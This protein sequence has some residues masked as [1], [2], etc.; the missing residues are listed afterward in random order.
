MVGGPLPSQQNYQQG[1]VRDDLRPTRSGQLLTF[2]GLVQ[3]Y[4]NYIFYFIDYFC[5]MMTNDLL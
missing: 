3:L 4:L 5:D 1:E 2:T